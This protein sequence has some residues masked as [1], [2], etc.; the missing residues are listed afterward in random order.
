MALTETP[1][2][3]RRA[4]AL[5][6]ALSERPKSRAKLMKAES[7][8]V[9]A[10]LA[11][12]E[13]SVADAER[14]MPTDLPGGYDLDAPDRVGPFRI[15]RRLASGG[16]GSVWLGSRDDG[17]YEQNVAVKFIHGELGVEASERFSEERRFLARLESPSIARLIDGGVADGR[18]YLVMEYVDGE[19]IDVFCATRPLRERL[20]LF[21]EA[22]EAVQYAHSQLIVHADLKTSNILV[23]QSGRVRLL[24][25]GIAR[26]VDAEDRPGAASPMTHAFA[27]P[28]RR[29]GG[30][31]S[32]ADDVFALGVILQDLLD[33]ANDLDLAA[34]ASRATAPS[35]SERYGSVAALL[36]D[37]QRWRERLPVSARSSTLRYRLERFLAR[38]GLAVAIAAG[39]ML[40]LAAAATIATVNYLEAERSRVEAN[41]RFLEVRAI[42]GFMLFE[43]YDRLANAPGTVE[44]RARLAETAGRYLD[45][46]R[47]TPNAP[48]DLRLET[49]QGYRRL[50]RV[51]GVSGTASLGRPSEAHRS[52]DAAERL[53]AGVIRTDPDNLEALELMGWIISDR[54]TLKADSSETLAVNARA[55][56]YFRRVLAIAP[57]REGARLGILTTE[58]GRAF[59][60]IWTADRPA[61][62][63]VV[64]RAALSDLRGRPF[65]SRA[66]DARVLEAH[67]LNRLGDATYYAGDILGSLAP[68]REAE[69]IINRSLAR[70]ETL[71]GLSR[72]G[73]SAWNISGS[74]G[75]LGR[76]REAL[77]KAREGISTVRRVLSF[78]PDADAEKQLLVLYGQEANL[79]SGLGER[80]AAL[81]PAAASVALRESR[82]QKEPRDPQR[83]RDLAVGL[84]AASRLFAAVGRK[85]Q[86]CSLARRSDAQWRAIQAAKHLGQ[87]D[88]ND[89]WPKARS[90]IARFCVGGR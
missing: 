52:L 49:A 23:D 53:T 37:L 31:P 46:L 25:F 56:S 76:R 58:K 13:A 63:V 84:E 89:T 69:A 78:G 20:K 2:T 85:A 87:R 62:A 12:L 21:G 67:L 83:A 47:V 90:S 51:Q 10:R 72:K 7:A 74:L 50:A 68:Y 86:A 16:M 8:A 57:D 30:A 54:W 36:G 80:Q 40:L 73:E 48:V 1:E 35:A 22:A 39:V 60:L 43:L 55:A 15:V 14:A 11:A 77:A 59:D 41:R 5:F 33:S 61:E 24:D 3:E 27:S 71:D 70:G 19:P 42:S 82:L 9:K 28:E 29:A 32:I 75:D 64:L 6:E 45:R 66:A 65:V 88:A 26:L 17:L 44:A 18:P 79:L 81:A 4:L 34:I 38:H